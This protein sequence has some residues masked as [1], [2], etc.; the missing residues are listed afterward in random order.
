MLHRA[1]TRTVRYDIKLL[2]KVSQQPM[3][4]VEATD[5]LRLV[6]RDQARVLLPRDRRAKASREGPSTSATAE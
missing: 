4:Y 3:G 1:E 2:S 6:R 5:G